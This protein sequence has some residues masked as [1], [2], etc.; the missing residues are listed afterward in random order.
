M[1]NRCMKKMLNVTNHQGNATQNHNE[2]SHWQLF[3][4][5]LKKTSV[6]NDGIMVGMQ[7]VAVTM[8]NCIG[9]SSKN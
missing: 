3:F 9:G 8:K 4:F 2:T 6:G 1:A 5:F 7:N